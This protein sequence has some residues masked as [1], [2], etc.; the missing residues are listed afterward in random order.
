MTV[1]ESTQLADGE[2]EVCDPR[3]ERPTVEWAPLADRQAGK[4]H[5]DIVL[6]DSMSDGGSG[7]STAID[8]VEQALKRRLADSS[9]RR[10]VRSGDVFGEGAEQIDELVRT[11]SAVVYFAPPMGSLTFTAVRFLSVLERRGVPCALVGYRTFDVLVED[12]R[13]RVGLPVR[14]VLM[15]NPLP[16]DADALAAAAD[17]AV[18]A[19]LRSVESPPPSGALTPKAPDVMLTGSVADVAA[20]FIDSEWTDGLP[21]VLPTRERVDAMLA[22]TSRR[23]DDMVTACLRPMG[24]KVRV[25]TVAVNA[26]MA[27]ASAEHLPLL[28]ATVSMFG[29]P[30]FESMT[31]SVNSFIFP[32]VVNG[33]V[34]DRLQLNAGLNALGAGN[35]SSSLIGRALRLVLQNAGEL[36]PGV[37]AFPV[38]GN[39]AGAS[40]VVAENEEASPWP[41]FAETLGLE[42]TTSTVSVF[43]GGFSHTGNFHLDS[44][45]RMGKVVAGFEPPLGVLAI[46]SPKRAS[47]LASEGAAKSDVEARITAAATLR[48]GSFRDSG[49][50]PTLVANA[51][52]AEKTRFAA[53]AAADDDELVRAFADNTVRVIVA[54]GDGAAVMQAWLVGYHDT[55]S[56][57]LW[58]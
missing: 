20:R 46:L 31:K 35:V 36:R 5:G 25:E 12:A 18:D 14:A 28:L 3:G 45:E 52:G 29:H 56:V 57:D 24:N 11:A 34:R 9:V 2:V 54:G 17:H 33:P 15:P 37:T 1:P 40:F 7:M 30:K 10:E 38:Q 26:V 47:M 43:F 16:D 49:F 8:A 22:G 27:G 19:L 51:T 58:S 44:I 39:A 50:Y 53:I 13:S 6:L 55:V 48:A 41:S 23:R 32:L 4:R 42:N 21:F